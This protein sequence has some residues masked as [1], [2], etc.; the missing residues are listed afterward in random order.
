MIGKKYINWGAFLLTLLF[1]LL[2]FQGQAKAAGETVLVDG[3]VLSRCGTHQVPI[4]G[5]ATYTAASHLVVRVDGVERLHSH[6]GSANWSAGLI[7]LGVGQHTATATVYADSEESHG[8]VLAT[9]SISFTVVA[10]QPA[11]T[12]PGDEKDCC[13]GKDPE[14]QMEGK[15]LGV[16]TS[17]GGGDT[18]PTKKLISLKGE[19]YN[20][21]EDQIEV[22][23]AK[24]DGTIVYRNFHM[25]AGT[26][27][28]D[29]IRLGSQVKIS[30]EEGSNIALI[31]QDLG[32]DGMENLWGAVNE[33]PI[34]D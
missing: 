28:R 33:S 13:P 7:T 17:I 10:C 4:T 34:Y 14:E 27:M 32:P 22:K 15:V 30:F 8:A 25:T 3:V 31:V 5:T 11:S 24:A 21:S 1:G 20:L 6:D 19:V 12:G 2:S 29:H 26:E 18:T 16:A 9:H 23:Y